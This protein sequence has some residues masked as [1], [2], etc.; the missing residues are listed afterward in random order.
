MLYGVFDL[1][2]V[3]R[4]PIAPALAFA[5]LA[6]M[7]RPVVAGKV[8]FGK[9]SHLLH[10][11]QQRGLFLGKY[12]FGHISGRSAGGFSLATRSFFLA[13]SKAGP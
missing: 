9:N 3:V 7:L 11:M 6:A 4:L 1:A 8:R 2:A 13:V 10:V 5:V 12:E